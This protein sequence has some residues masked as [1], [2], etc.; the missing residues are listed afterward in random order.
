MS[1]LRHADAEATPAMAQTLSGSRRWVALGILAVSLGIVVLDGT[2]VGVSLPVIIRDLQMSLTNAEWVNSLYS[3]VFAA[4]LLTAGR[5]GDRFGRRTTLIV[6]IAI[7][8]FG[9]VLAAM[10]GG[11]AALIGA[12]AV[13]G[14]GGALI[15]PSTL[16]TVNATFRGKDRAVAFGVWGA[17]MSGAAA[18]GPLLG[19]C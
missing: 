4:L 13:Q 15:L 14:V 11:A 17:V 12:R 1:D 8:A 3:V 16:S 10:S 6:G 5:L 19:G 18:L 2:I 9:S 7:F